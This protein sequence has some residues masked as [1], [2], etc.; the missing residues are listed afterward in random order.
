MLFFSM[1][2]YY[3]LLGRYYQELGFSGTQIGVLFSTATFITMFMQPVW[4]LIC[5]KK[6]KCKHVFILM[7]AVIAL[8]VLSVPYI[9]N[10][11]LLLIIMS[12]H[13]TFQC[14]LF[15]LLDTMIYKDIYDFGSIRL[16]GSIGFSAMVLFS[17]RISEIIG[18]Q[19]MFFIY[20][21]FMLVSLAIAL[22]I[23]EQE[24]AFVEKRKTEKKGIKS[25]F[26]KNYILFSI[27][28]F[29]TMGA[30]YTSSQYFSILFSDKG[31]S[32]TAFGITY[33]FFA[34]SEVPFLKLS[35]KIINKYGA[36]RII[37]ISGV[38][39]LARNFLYMSAK[40]YQ[41]LLYSSILM[42]SFIGLILPAVAVFIKEK[43]EPENRATA[44]T[45]Y[46]AISMG[47]GPMIFQFSSGIIYDFA[48]ISAIYMF[49]CFLIFIGIL[50]SRV[51]ESDSKSSRRV[52]NETI[53]A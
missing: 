24:N 26:K 25:L 10:Y 37:L 16:W 15:P 18:I 13:F 8:I 35:Q 6:G 49:L 46:S 43:T 22:K 2:A 39:L 3:P 28:G 27:M 21:L 42:G 53:K 23:R 31:G 32:M 48:N 44:V 9:K 34:I 47:L 33:F 29:F 5:D 7:H 30:F 20:S 1:A 50:I 19:S 51:L 41:V 45:L 36:E 4:G 17:G 38:I 11:W 40:T 14:G 12:V 52:S